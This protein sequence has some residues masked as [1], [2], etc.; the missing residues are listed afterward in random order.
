MSRSGY[1]DDLDDRWQFIMWRGTVA[2][3]IRGK[4]GQA[5]LKEMLAAMDALPVKRLVANELAAPDLIPC[6]HWGLFEAESVCAIGS[7]GKARGIDMS[8]L[9]PDDSATVAGTFGIAG[10]MAQE[11]V[12]INDEAGP[13]K[14]TPERRFERVR[15]W[16]V[17]HIKADPAAL[18]VSFA[19]HSPED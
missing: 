17:H 19:H 14:E 15:A 11:I 1:S 6:S 5:F 2:S 8:K 7:V 3:A 18:V 4:R 9:D 10:P 16:I 12:W 13:W